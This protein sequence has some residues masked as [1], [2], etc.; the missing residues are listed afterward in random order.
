MNG[1]DDGTCMRKYASYETDFSISAWHRDPYPNG[2][3]DLPIKEQLR[4]GGRFKIVNDEKTRDSF[5]WRA[6]QT[7][8]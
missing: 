6:N 4:A 1:G 2:V 7:L 8:A 3:H 5:F